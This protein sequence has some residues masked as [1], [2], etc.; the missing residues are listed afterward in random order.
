LLVHIPKG[1]RVSQARLRTRR[2]KLAELPP[3]VS[4]KRL[5]LKPSL[6]PSNS[7]ID[8][9]SL[10]LSLSNGSLLGGRHQRRRRCSRRSNCYRNRSSHQSTLAYMSIS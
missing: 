2:P 8:L 1:Y 9:K 5:S 10:R 3:R 7:G 6:P 4:P